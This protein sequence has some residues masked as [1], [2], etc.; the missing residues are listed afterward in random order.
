V[1]A[2]FEDYEIGDTFKLSDYNG[3]LN[4]GNYHII[5]IDLSASW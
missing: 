2:G 1:C 3:E 4:G 5:F